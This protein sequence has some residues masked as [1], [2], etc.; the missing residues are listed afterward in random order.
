MEGGLTVGVPGATCRVSDSDLCCVIAGDGSLSRVS[1]SEHVSSSL[2]FEN[3][4]KTH[5]QPQTSCLSA[6]EQ[7]AH[8]K[9]RRTVLVSA[10]EC[11]I[12]LNKI[13]NYVL[14]PILSVTGR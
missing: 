3:N 6:D 2:S 8:G 10:L 14:S 13:K 7:T 12:P 1:G 4:G 11:I 9:S 5:H